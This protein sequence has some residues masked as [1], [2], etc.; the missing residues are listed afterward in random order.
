MEPILGLH[1][2]TSIIIINKHRMH[3]GYALG[4]HSFAEQ[5]CNKNDIKIMLPPH[6]KFL[7][8]GTLIYSFYQIIIDEIY[9][10]TSEIFSSYSVVRTYLFE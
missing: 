4:N 3:T 8:M 9:L 5:G 6:D 7:L 2:C 1:G 10:L